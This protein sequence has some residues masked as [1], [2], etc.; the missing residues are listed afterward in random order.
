[1]YK[2]YKITNM[3]NNKS[4]I[5]I[6]K[7]KIEERF[8]KHIKDSQCP[9]YPL[10]CAIQKYGH[11]NFK[12]ELLEE[13]DDRSYISNREQPTIEMYESHISKHGYNVA[14]GGYGGDLGDAAND[15]RR[16]TMKSK[17]DEEKRLWISKRNA[18]V[19]GR[20]KHNHEGKR[21]Q[22]LKVLGNKHAKGLVH[23][24]ET[25][26][27]ISEANK[28]P[29]SEYTKH[30]MS[31]KAKDRG[32]GPQLQGKKVGCICCNKEWDLGNYTQHIRKIY[33]LQ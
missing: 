4:Y 25:K 17:T 22:A 19:L 14:K 29:K 23:T 2:L 15:K 20:N 10:H 21:Q 8:K 5:G 28:H 13:S 7:L 11:E 24:E 26:K 33:E 18:T 6:T 27:V 31:L 32:T 30:L 12:V 9:L 3:I 1:M 16:Q